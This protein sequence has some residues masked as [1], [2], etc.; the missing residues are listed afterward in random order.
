MSIV[1][2]RRKKKTDIF[3]PRKSVQ[4]AKEKLGPAFFDPSL[5]ECSRN[6]IELNKLVNKWE[7]IE[8]QMV[9][10]L[11]DL[12]REQK[13]LARS[14]KRSHSTN[15]SSSKGV[16]TEEYIETLDGKQI[17]PG[18][19]FKSNGE[20][21]ASTTSLSHLAVSTSDEDINTKDDAKLSQKSDRLSYNGIDYNKEIEMLRDVIVDIC[22][23]LSKSR[24]SLSKSNSG[25]LKTFLR[26]H[27]NEYTSVSDYTGE[28]YEKPNDRFAFQPGS[29]ERRNLHKQTIKTPST[30]ACVGCQFKLRQQ[31]DKLQKLKTETDKNVL[32]RRWSYV[33]VGKYVS[34]STSLDSNSHLLRK[35]SLPFA[36]FEEHKIDI[37]KDSKPSLVRLKVDSE[38][39]PRK[40]VSFQHKQKE[41]PLTEGRTKSSPCV[42]RK[43]HLA[44]GERETVSETHQKPKS[45]TTK[46]PKLCG[47]RSLESSLFKRSARN[48]RSSA[49]SDT[50]IIGRCLDSSQSFRS[51]V[52]SRNSSRML[53]DFE[54][55]LS[56]LK[57]FQ[58]EQDKQC[59][60]KVKKFL[61][62]IDSMQNV[63]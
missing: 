2:P 10:V 32:K 18:F 23:E 41:H 24:I 30:R 39:I 37:K 33:P 31:S 6:A 52:S 58:A 27:S 61:K 47:G 35:S 13:S 26:A 59:E 56:L 1:L 44:T 8:K 5:L 15:D 40:T 49:N 4:D 21:K 22:E 45:A 28:L 9:K 20:L 46:T 55:R 63:T 17:P 12:S 60:T 51:G 34:S 57:E 36:R 50:F 38:I 19:R 43:D 7:D 11:R 14:F 29:V 53:T 3:A 25:K 42:R 54:T 16:S 48:S 62:N